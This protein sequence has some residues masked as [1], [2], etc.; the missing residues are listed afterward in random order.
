MTRR[1]ITRPVARTVVAGMFAFSALGVTACSETSGDE[2]GTSVE[3]V[4]E[5]AVTDDLAYQGAFDNEFLTDLD[6]YEGQQVTVSA[7]V[8]E[9]ISDH[10]FTI[11]GGDVEP[12]LVVSAD[13]MNDLQAG[14]VVSVTGTVHTAF[15]LPAVEEQMGTDLED[16]RFADWGQEPYIEASGVDT[17]PEENEG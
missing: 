2:A 10:A 1:L 8:D 3:D 15:D 12:L 13:E 9:V 11:A 4:Q 17:S 5:E 6:G 16:D 14:N 7:D